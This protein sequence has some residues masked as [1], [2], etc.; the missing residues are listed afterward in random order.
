[1]WE[2]KGCIFTRTD[3]G[4]WNVTHAQIPTVDML[5]EETLRI[6]YATRNSLGQ[7]AISYFDVDAM[8]P[9][10]IRYEHKAPILEKGLRGCFDDCGVMPSCVVNA[11]GQKL[12]YYIGWNVRNTVSYQLSL[13]LAV[14]ENDGSFRR[15]S[16][17][18]VFDRGIHDPYL[19]GS[20]YVR[21]EDGRWRMWYTSG[22]GW[23]LLDGR[24]E[25]RYLIRYA[26]SG[27][28][29]AW[30]RKG[31]VSV[32]YKNEHE[33]IGRPI[34]HLDG[35]VYK[36]WYSY[37]DTSAY[38]QDPTK[39]YKI[40]YGESPDGVAFTR[41]DERVGIDVSPEGWDSQMLAY[42][43]VVICGEKS[44]MFYN[45]NGFG[46]SGIGYAVRVE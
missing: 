35:G 20:N 34:V 29:I 9:S 2:K 7:S 30:E 1:M 11:G 15:Y 38:R 10:R 25:P 32:P 5:D 44:Y 27:D 33:A 23:E 43:N 31:T 39:A 26:E 37:R 16:E 41:M 8:N 4:G 45:G 3:P 36:M 46:Q 14:Q 12:L 42:A 21:I 6:Y 22:T 13:G 24:P 18:P 28:G 40:G 19:S 17:G